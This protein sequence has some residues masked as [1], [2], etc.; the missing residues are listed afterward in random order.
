[1]KKIIILLCLLILTGCTD[2]IEI[3]DLGIA[4]GIIIDYK[5]D[6]FEVTTQLIINEQE[7]EIKV[8]TTKSPSIE[9]AVTEVSKLSNKEL[10]ASDLKVLIITEN[11]IENNINYYDIFLRNSKLKMDFKVYLAN[12]EISKDIL[13]MYDQNDGSS[14]YIDQMISYNEKVFSS[15]LGLEFINLVKLSL[16]YGVNP[17]YPNLTIIKNNDE[18]IIYLD[19][20]VS[21][22]KEFKRLELDEI[23]GVF[24]NILTNNIKDTTINI[25]CDGGLFAIELDTIDTSKEFKKNTFDIDITITSKLKSYHC[26]DKYDDKTINLLEKLSKK[27]IN[28]ETI[29]LINKAKENEND[30]FGF[31]NYIYNHVDNYFNFK[32][33]SWDKEFKNIKFKID[34][35]IS[36]SSTGETRERIGDKYGKNK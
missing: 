33:K 27:Y 7:S 24:Y 9:E 1:M 18:D 34:N 13:K 28:Q 17:V 35:E 21:Y 32:K 4:T 2:Y 8:Y 31:G 15:S 25:P 36:I 3:N 14:L 5:D 20:L 26:K 16:E 12:S 6:M 23:D 29:K 10:F 30:I 19:K 22:N 11:I